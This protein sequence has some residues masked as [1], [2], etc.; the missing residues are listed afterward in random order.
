MEDLRLLSVCYGKDE[1]EKRWVESAGLLMIRV[2]THNRAGRHPRTRI[3]DSGRVGGTVM[4]RGIA[5]AKRSGHSGRRCSARPRVESLEGR[6][7]MAA[8]VQSF[9]I[10][11]QASEIVKGADG[12]LW[13]TEFGNPDR[14]GRISPS[15]A[16]TE[17]PLGTSA[18]IHGLA[19]GGDGNIWFIGFHSAQVG[20]ITPAGTITEFPLPAGT[21]PSAIATGP[22][23][24][25]W[26]AADHMFYYSTFFRVSPDGSIT[27]FPETPVQTN[28]GFLENTALSAGPGGQLWFVAPSP[29][30]IG[31]ITTSGVVSYSSLSAIPGLGSQAVAVSMTEGAAGDLWFLARA[32]SDAVVG[33]VAADGTIS[34]FPIQDY[35]NA[36]TVGPDGN[37]WITQVSSF[38]SPEVMRVTPS[39]SVSTFTIPIS[40]NPKQDKGLST[41]GI[42]TGP[43]GNLWITVSPFYFG[44]GATGPFEVVRL[45]VARS[46]PDGA[47][48]RHNR[49]PPRSVHHPKAPHPQMG[50]RNAKVS[51]Y[52]R[53]GE[54]RVGSVTTAMAVL[55][56]NRPLLVSELTDHSGDPES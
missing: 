50:H 28:S 51:S 40:R 16:L 13:F 39:G 38:G 10:S 56:A 20:R 54:K 8:A 33:H 7:L 53:G 52:G 2:A 22:D 21:Q 36:I 19:A 11:A 46:T 43:D 26:I 18:D 25:I 35:G 47:K 37:L 49:R 55:P 23:G 3:Q 42:T 45:F 6:E 15:G 17:F 14:I 5:R 48:S 29:G 32:T 24:D 4:L 27:E 41:F 44:P 12:N 30:Y 1:V 9:P 31:H 34:A